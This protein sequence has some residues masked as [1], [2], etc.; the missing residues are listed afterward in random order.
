MAKRDEYLKGAAGRNAG[1][2]RAGKSKE[3]ITDTPYVFPISDAS[4]I[5][6]W[7]HALRAAGLYS[8]DEET[9]RNQYRL[10]SL[11]KFFI[12]QMSMAGQKVL[13]EHL[14]GHLGYL[15]ASSR[16]VD[17][18]QAG[19]EY[20][21]VQHVVTIG[22]PPEFREAASELTGKLQLQGESID[23]LRAMNEKLVAQMA[24]IQEENA[25][26]QERSHHFE[27]A[28][29]EQKNNF[30]LMVDLFGVLAGEYAEQTHDPRM[31]KAIRDTIAQY[32]VDPYFKWP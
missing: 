6:M 28:L 16:Q 12:S 14:A 7:E 9:G 24:K 4:V 26:L 31:G 13:A 5:A 11:R 8:A 17:S 20:L 32:K 19:K 29:D 3:K 2:V 22:I 10:H 27:Q 1:L 30:N 23:G 21:A 15:D 18:E 25:A